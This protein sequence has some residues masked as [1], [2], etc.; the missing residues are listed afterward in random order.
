MI[1]TILKDVDEEKH[2]FLIT[3]GNNILQQLSVCFAAICSK[4]QW[5]WYQMTHSCKVTI[6]QLSKI[7]H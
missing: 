4:Q 1:Y 6:M 5:H 2:F 7:Q 3:I